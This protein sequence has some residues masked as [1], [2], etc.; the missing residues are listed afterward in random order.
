MEML[1][2]TRF[3]AKVL[4]TNPGM[5]MRYWSRLYA[6]IGLLWATG[7]IGTMGRTTWA[8]AD[9]KLKPR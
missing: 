8:W 4:R 3:L 2:A 9:T 5:T 1:H 7:Q 6:A